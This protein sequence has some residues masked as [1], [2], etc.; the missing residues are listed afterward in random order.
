MRFWAHV[1]R[2]GGSSFK[3]AGF[4]PPLGLSSGAEPLTLARNPRSLRPK[5]REEDPAEAEHHNA[6][7]ARGLGSGGPARKRRP[8]PHTIGNGGRRDVF[9]NGEFQFFLI[10]G[11]VVAPF[12]PLLALKMLNRRISF[13]RLKVMRMYSGYWVCDDEGRE[14]RPREVGPEARISQHWL[15][16]SFGT[17]FEKELLV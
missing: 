10:D 9:W 13:H 2:D 17:Y 11:H 15:A 6:Q 4:G 16:P 7:R 14:L 8:G 5:Q 3:H 1:R 12:R